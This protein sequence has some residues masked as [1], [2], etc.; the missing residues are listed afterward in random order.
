M[1][2]GERGRERYAKATA[3]TPGAAAPGRGSGAH[4]KVAIKRSREL[5]RALA[6]A[7]GASPKTG[8]D[9]LRRTFCA[10]LVGPGHVIDALGSADTPAA[11]P[12]FDG[13][14][15]RLRSAAVPVAPP[16]QSYQPAATAA[17]ATH[18]AAGH[19]RQRQLRR[20]QPVGGVTGAQEARVEAVEPP[21]FT[22]GCHRVLI[23]LLLNRKRTCRPARPEPAVASSARTRCRSCAR[24][25]RS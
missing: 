21:M 9:E 8:T 6:N 24:A 19:D 12:L 10:F 5:A 15:A 18:G 16:R 20:R 11:P 2:P 4:T 25:S 1:G 13:G 22:A 7:C 17:A 14:P 23:P 3:A